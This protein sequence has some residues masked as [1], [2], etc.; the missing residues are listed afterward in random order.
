MSWF[1][2]VCISEAQ[3]NKQTFTVC[4][5]QIIVYTRF[6][7]SP[8]NM[9]FSYLCFIYSP[10][11]VV[12]AGSISTSTLPQY[13][14]QTSYKVWQQQIVKSLLAQNEL[15]ACLFI[16]SGTLWSFTL[17]ALFPPLLSLWNFFPSFPLTFW[18]TS[19]FF[20]PICKLSPFI[21]YVL[22]PQLFHPS[23]SYSSLSL[24]FYYHPPPTTVPTMIKAP[25][26]LMVGEAHRLSWSA[27]G[28]T[29]SSSANVIRTIFAHIHTHM[30][31]PNKFPSLRQ[32]ATSDG[33][34]ASMDYVWRF[35][36]PSPSS[37]P[38]FPP[39][40]SLSE[41]FSINHW[42]TNCGIAL[43]ICVWICMCL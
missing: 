39:C 23:I 36:L 41:W 40:P 27:S 17:S 31:T 12:W 4:I 15:R 43:C 11:I 7:F 6:Y 9:W 20:S 28:F 35:T 1:S 21:H 14:Q 29:V 8:F 24:L 3:N 22:W 10:V 26:P 30:N 37:R 13:P 2:I 32:T 42:A 25:C 38:H 33:L 34:F 18:T 19:H 5:L 16:S